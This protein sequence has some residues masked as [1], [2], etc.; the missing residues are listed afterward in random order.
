M[1]LSQHLNF[2]RLNRDSGLD[3]IDY[4]P[5]YQFKNKVNIIGIEIELENVKKFGDDL[6]NHWKIIEDGSLKY[7][8]REFTTM[9]IKS[10]QTEYVLKYLFDRLNEDVAVSHR[11]STH[12]HVNFRKSTTEDIAKFLLLYLVFEQV[13]YKF[14]G[15]NR[16]KNIFCMPIHTTWYYRELGKLFANPDRIVTHPFWNKYAGINL[17]PLHDGRGTIEFRQLAR[18]KDISKICVWI[19]TILTIKKEA[20]KFEYK[21]LLD[22][23]SGLLYTS[24]YEGF[25]WQIFGMEMGN[26]ILRKA[27]EPIDLGNLVRAGVVFTRECI[28][29][30]DLQVDVGSLKD[31]VKSDIGK[32]FQLKDVEVRSISSR[33]LGNDEYYRF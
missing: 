25:F 5:K 21:E 15:Y 27:K 24:E 31:I 19:D 23:V 26:T 13:L 1:L 17:A 29:F 9:P 28:Y 6:V 22:K 30:K 16:N 4:K 18:T 20:A 10:Y 8:G 32:F 14:V 7:K 2:G 12:V 11:T 33:V 3:N